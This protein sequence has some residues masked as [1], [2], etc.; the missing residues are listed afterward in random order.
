MGLFGLL[1]RGLLFTFFDD[2]TCFSI[3]KQFNIFIQGHTTNVITYHIGNF[4]NN[5]YL[6]LLRS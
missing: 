1:R 6:I 5:S 4:A 3:K 2:L